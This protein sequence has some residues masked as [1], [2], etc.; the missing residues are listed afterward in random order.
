MGVGMAVA[1]AIATIFCAVNDVVRDARFLAGIIVIASVGATIA[2][3]PWAA[4]YGGL[5]GLGAATL[6]FRL[7]RT[8]TLA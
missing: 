3:G 2:G 1:L 8:A 6:A 7:D 5:I 4:G